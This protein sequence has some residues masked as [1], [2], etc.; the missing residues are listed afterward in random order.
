MNAT[1]VILIKFWDTPDKGSRLGSFLRSWGA[2]GVVFGFFGLLGLLLLVVEQLLVSSDTNQILWFGVC[3]DVIIKLSAVP[4]TLLTEW[5]RGVSDNCRG[6]V[7]VWSKKFVPVSKVLELSILF[8]ISKKEDKLSALRGVL[9]VYLSG[10]R[11]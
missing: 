4:A 11:A 8:T 5:M 1:F 10:H 7:H 2:G 6:V 3:R 9:Y